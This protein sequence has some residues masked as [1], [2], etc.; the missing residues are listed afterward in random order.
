MPYLYR[1]SKIGIFNPYTAQKHLEA[2]TTIPHPFNSH[3]NTDITKKYLRD[4]FRALQEEAVGLGRRNV[5][6][7]DGSVDNSTWVSRSVPDDENVEED[8]GLLEEEEMQVVQ[9][10]NMVMWIGGVVQSKEGQAVPVSVEVDI[11]QENQTALLISAHFGM[12]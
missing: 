11:N 4:Q 7:D 1:Y 6:F 3:A 12:C 9:G 10:D 2:L 5:R 8:E